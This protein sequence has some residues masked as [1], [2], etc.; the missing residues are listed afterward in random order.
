MNV[1]INARTNARPEE[2]A[3]EFGWW[4]RRNGG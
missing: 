2:I 3:A 4:L 1:T